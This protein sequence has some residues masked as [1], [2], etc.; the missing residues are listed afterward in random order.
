MWL[1]CP[2]AWVHSYLSHQVWAP[3]TLE[4][5]PG[6]TDEL[7]RSATSRTRSQP[8]EYWSRAWEKE[9]SL[10][11]LCGLT[12]TPLAQ[13]NGLALWLESLP[14]IPVSRSQLLA[15]A[16]ERTID[17]TSGQPSPASSRDPNRSG[18]SWRMWQD[19]FDLG[20]STTSDPTLNDRVTAVRRSSSELL[21]WE[22][23][24]RGSASSSWPTPLGSNVYQLRNKAGVK[25]L[26]GK[27]KSWRTPTRS[28]EDT[29]T[30]PGAYE[31]PGSRIK[32]GDQA[33]RI[34]Q[35]R[36]G[37][38]FP[39]RRMA[40]GERS[41]ASTG[42]LLNPRFVEWLMGLPAGWVSL[43]QTSCDCWATRLS[44]DKPPW[45]GASSGER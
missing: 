18:S 14:A 44:Q 29:G 5:R 3:S 21:T 20:T 35:E 30:E 41:T 32:L 8:P 45:R 4:L 23:R 40:T 13:R 39:P 9:P 36:T 6:V 33:A 24:N 26:A 2:R 16:A 15:T 43:G 7:G 34:Y 37:R 27:A 10:K 38:P 22:R 12:L 42:L 1:H 31:K 17:D 19:T 11:L 25:M 28:N